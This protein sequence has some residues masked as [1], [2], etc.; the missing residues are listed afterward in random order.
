[1]I[2]GINDSELESILGAAAERGVERATYVLLR[3]PHELKQ[4]FTDWLESHYPARK[5][6]VLSR[7]RDMRGGRLNDPRFG[8]RM[9][10]DGRHAELL[11]RRFEVAC[12]RLGLNRERIR[13][14][15]SQFRPPARG[16]GQG[17]LFA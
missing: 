7:V 1:M 17:R 13:L 14:D 9:S 16:D 5:A 15:A 10:G 3:L 2:P 4:L 11:R 12:R 8:S 6:K